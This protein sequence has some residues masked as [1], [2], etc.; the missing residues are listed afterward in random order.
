MYNIRQDYG[1]VSHGHQIRVRVRLGLVCMYVSITIYV[2]TA[3][4]I[5]KFKKYIGFGM[6]TC[7]SAVQC[8][9]VDPP[10]CVCGSS[11]HYFILGLR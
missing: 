7:R 5:L 3:A 10:L 8:A 6:G 4:Y 2:R 9:P 1:T 11:M